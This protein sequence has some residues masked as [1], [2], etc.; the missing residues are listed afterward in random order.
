MCDRKEEER[1]G[2]YVLLKCA[3]YEEIFPQIGKIIKLDKATVTIEWLHGAYSSNFVS[4]KQ[5]GKPICETFPRRS[6]MIT[7][8]LTKSM[9]LRRDDVDKIKNLYTKAEFV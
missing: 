7:I 4:W 1:V 9:R 2:Q 3:K 5:G 8:N 6:I